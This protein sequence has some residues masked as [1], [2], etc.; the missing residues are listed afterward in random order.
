M[1][2]ITLDISDNKLAFFMELVENLKFVK[3]SKEYQIPQEHKDIVME[4]LLEIE[5]NPQS[6][7]DWDEVK[8]KFWMPFNIKIFSRA[9]EDI[10]LSREWYNKQK[11]GLGDTFRS[12]VK[13]QIEFISTSPFAFSIKYAEIRCSPVPKFPFQ[14]H[15]KPISNTMEVHII[16]VFHTSRN[17]NIWELRDSP[18]WFKWLEL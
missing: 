6:L 12:S 11:D 14:I 10:E 1:A 4:R 17:P 3:V 16:A 18:R 15:Y 9:F 5:K 8:D 7:L 2:R 13:E